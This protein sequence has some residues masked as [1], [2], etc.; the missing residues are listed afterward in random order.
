[1]KKFLHKSFRKVISLYAGHDLRRKIPLINSIYRFFNIHLSADKA[2]IDGHIIYVDQVDSLGLVSKGIYEPDETKLVNTLIKPGDIVIDLGANIGYFTLL[3]ARLVGPNGKVYAFEPH[4]YSFSL[5]KK[6]IEINGYQ[7]IEAIQKAASNQKGFLELYQDPFNNTD[8]RIYP[9][10]GKTKQI[11]I[12]TIS[13]DEYFKEL[14]YVNFMKIDTQG[15]EFLILSG[16]KKLL[17]RSPNI[18]MLLEFWPYGLKR[19]GNNAQDL[20]TIIKEAGFLIFDISNKEATIE[21]LINC[22]PSTIRKHTN[23]LCIR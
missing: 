19:I 13:L 4:P 17:A 11:Q 23:L 21:E 14:P 12:E 15:A 20:L 2:M 5:L 7:N 3:F 8:H 22:Y 10:D 16:M 18:K 6:N 9:Q 1:M